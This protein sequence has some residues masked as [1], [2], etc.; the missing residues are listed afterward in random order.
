MPRDDAIKVAQWLVVKK[1]Q[2]M[3]PALHCSSSLATR[4][5]QAAETAGL[6]ISDVKFRPSGEPITPA[7]AETLHRVGAVLES[8][9]TMVDMNGHVGDGCG[10]PQSLDDVHLRSDKIAVIVRH[11][12]T[13]F[14]P[15]VPA[16]VFT[17]LHPSGHRIIINLE[18]G[19]YADVEERECGCFLG[20]L[21]LKTH[22]SNIR[23]H[24]KLTSEGVTFIGTRLFDLVEVVMPSRFGGH[25]GDYQ[26]VEGEVAGLP[27]VSVLV[28]PRVGALDESRVIDTVLETLESSH[29]GAGGELMTNQWRQANTLRVVRR[30]PYEVGG[31]KVPPIHFIRPS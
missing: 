28:A 8:Q 10:T 26:L 15:S 21:G 30:D 22:L 17:S 23:S 16:L 14:G 27:K 19:D 31:R 29:A 12:E 20:Q 13:L 4:V 18:G 2:G 9:Y 5:C 11:K 25:V 24:E 3:P 7:R 6:D 1:A